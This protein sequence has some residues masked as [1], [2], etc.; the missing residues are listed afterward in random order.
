VAELA[1]ELPRELAGE[2]RAELAGVVAE[3][4]LGWLR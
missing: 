4:T 1:G 3:I 2:L